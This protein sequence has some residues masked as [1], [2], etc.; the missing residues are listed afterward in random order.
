VRGV[1]RPAIVA[2]DDD[3]TGAARL[4]RELRGR[5]GDDYDIVVDRAADAARVDLEARA[6]AGTPVAL[7]LADHDAGG[8]ELLRAAHALHPHA[9]RGLLLQWGDNRAA[10]EDVMRHLAAGE[11]DYFVVKPTGAPDERF[12]RAVT[13]FLDEWWRL[14]GTPFE[15]IRVVGDE[16]SARAHE[17][18][19]LLQRHDLP[20]GFYA[21]DSPAGRAVLAEVAAPGGAGPVVVLSNGRAL[22]DPT[23]VEVAD[24]VGGR[25]RP[26]AGTYDVVVVGAGPAGLAVAVTA[27]SEGLR[28]ALIERTAL[29]GQAG[30]SSLIRNYLGFPRGISGAELAARAV[31]QAI[32]FGTE[33]VYGSAAMALTTEGGLHRVTLSD[34]PEV[35]ARTVV[36]A[37][38]V[39]YR[40]LDVPAL[41]PFVGTGVFYGA[42][43]S[44]ARMLA[45]EHVYVVGG[46]NSA[47]QA[48]M[49]LARYARQVTILVRS[50]SLAASMSEY[51]IRSIEASP[52]IDVRYA[53]EIVDGGGEERL[54]WVGVRDRGSGSTERVP[55][56]G[57]FVLIG[58]EPLTDWLPDTIE[59]DRWGYL[60]AGPLGGDPS[61]RT[62]LTTGG[63]T[64]LI[65]ETSLPGVFAVGDV[66][67]GSIKRVASAAGE[68]AICVRLIHEHLGAASAPGR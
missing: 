36:I 51:L 52:T 65:F 44:E 34:A 22:V 59:R 47:G 26:G 20:Y 14:R 67:R 15:A 3:E 64:P 2:H 46:G 13:E 23:N 49:H 27:A 16:H 25:T 24:A 66:R 8:P 54:E 29:G 68:G 40:R 57:V 30:T 32:L 50:G 33:I 6:A 18:C 7:V 53:S 38:G 39:S 63:R 41:E 48:A 21:E 56:A 11:A 10:R 5:Y 17:I 31:D 37:T 19:D 60:L 42:A 9:R 45:G 28:V 1:A 55:T 43:M 62:K 12:H 61:G 4:D 35:P 58:A